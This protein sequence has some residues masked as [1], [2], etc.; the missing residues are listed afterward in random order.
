MARTE[1]DKPWMG[2]LPA[3]PGC[4]CQ[5]CRPDEWYDEL[6]RR[7][8]ETVLEHGWQVMLVADDAGCSH[9]DHHDHPADDDGEP[10]PGFAYTV[11]LWHRAG[12]PELLMSGLDHGLMHR[13]LNGIAER[14]MHGLRLAPGDG[15][16]DVLAGVPVAVEQVSDTGLLETVTWSGWF[17]RREPEALAIVWPDRNGL[18]AWQ[19]GAPAALEE[20]QPGGWR[21]PIE[22]TGGLATDPTWVFPVPPDHRAFSCVH[23]VDGGAAVLWAAR[24]SDEDRGED[25]SIHCGAPGHQTEDMRIVHL[26]HLVR[27]APSLRQIGDLGL[28]E[29]AWRNDADSPWRTGRLP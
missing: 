28:D 21:V 12:H 18:F 7:V 23:V 22:H 17:H 9:P 6:D 26:A 29:E 16:E 25:W 20:R 5:I 3:A 13:A 2:P 24:E 8:I 4:D 10:G 19:P 14:I 15:L 11:G 27:S 1:D